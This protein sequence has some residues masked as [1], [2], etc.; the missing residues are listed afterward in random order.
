MSDL[1]GNTVDRLLR[2]EAHIISGNFCVSLNNYKCSYHI[3]TDIFVRKC[4]KLYNDSHIF[5]QKNQ[6]I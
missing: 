5:Q 6:C 2:V 1:V 3:N 4:K